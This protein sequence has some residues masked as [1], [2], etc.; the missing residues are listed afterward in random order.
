[1]SAEALLK[2]PIVLT[3]IVR[4][5]AADL[6][7]C[8]ASVRPYVERIIVVDT[9]SKDETVAIAKRYVDVVEE[10]QGCNN[11]AGQIEDFSA[12]RNHALKLA[13]KKWPKLHLGM[14]LDGDDLLEGGEH[15]VEIAAEMT[16]PSTSPEP[17]LSSSTSDAP[18]G[19][20]HLARP[21]TVVAFPYDVGDAVYPR[22]RIFPLHDVEW[23]GVVHE[24]LV[25]KSTPM[26]GRGAIVGARHDDRVVVRHAPSPGKLYKTRELG[27]NLRILR[28]QMRRQGALE[29]R[30]LYYLG[31]E[32]LRNGRI[33]EGLKW[34]QAYTQVSTWDEERCLACMRMAQAHLGRID[35]DG[36]EL[37][38][39]R[40]VGARPDW[41]EPRLLVASVYFQ[42]GHRAHGGSLDGQ[43]FCRVATL[44]PEALALAPATGAVFL[45][46][47]LRKNAHLQLHVAR[48][49]L[50]DLRGALE[51]VT[52]GL[53]DHPEDEG[54]LAAR[55]QY[56]LALGLKG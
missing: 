40:A 47:S 35:Y 38:A 33:S 53:V 27:R 13:K 46:R 55:G 26:S 34:L 50:G 15:L 20:Q 23:R 32:C 36:A 21:Q 42:R 4:D 45:D 52:A 44:I 30:G 51:S 11:A 19:A 5:E 14:W 28:T 43:D 39:L 3:M 24:T 2:A 12:A 29:P 6:A 25:R 16:A 18:Y 31:D 54:L 22:E 17:F 9:G 37:C 8:L 41:A 1:M 49:H 7:T 48:A 10:W 56:K